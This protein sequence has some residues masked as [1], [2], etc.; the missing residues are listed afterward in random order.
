MRS[1][2]ESFCNFYE[3]P[4]E[5]T[6]CLLAD[7][8]KIAASEYFPLFKAHV[9]LYNTDNPCFSYKALLNSSSDVITNCG[10]DEYSVNLLYFICLAEHCKEK[11]EKAGISMD[12]YHKSMLDL[13]W[14]LMECKKV[15]GIWGSF[16]AWWF[17][18]FF[19]L[20]RFAMGRLQFEIDP[21]NRVYEKNGIKLGYGDFVINVHIPSSG[22]LYIEDCMESFAMAEKFYADYFPDGVAKFTCHSWLLSK[23]HEK[24]LP[25]DGGIRK[26]ADLFDVVEDDPNPK[27]S[28][29]WRIFGKDYN[30][31]TEDFPAETSLQRAYLKLLAD[32][33]ITSSGLGYIF[34][35]D[36]KI[37]NK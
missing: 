3:Y 15:K 22:K 2:I 33:N 4:A 18:R 23:L 19:D 29:L 9:D 6:A 11:Y 21:S 17:P 12:F 37:I 24:Y 28:N 31:S 34:F 8:D 26:F 30:G 5:A 25:A 1:Q 20:S 35:K 16:V 32:G 10:V 27:G 13:K 14:K 7:F 36:G